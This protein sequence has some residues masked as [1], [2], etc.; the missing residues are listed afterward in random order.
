MFWML[1]MK[2]EKSMIKDGK[3]VRI[4]MADDDED[5]RFMAHEAMD[6]I[7]HLLRPGHLKQLAMILDDPEASDNDRFVAIELLKNANIAAGRILPGC[8]DTGTAI[9]I[10]YKGQL[11]FTGS[12]D[13]EALSRGIYE[14]YDQRNLRYS[15]MTP[16][17]SQ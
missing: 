2:M 14:A 1:S 9:A 4:L 7:A 5:D 17:V 16:C 15:Q 3:P 8:Q 12:D 10:G 11:V 13:I 6:D